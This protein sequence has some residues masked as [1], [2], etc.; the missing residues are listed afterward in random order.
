[1]LAFLLMDRCLLLLYF[2]L[3]FTII[4]Y[5]Y[6]YHLL[7]IS[8]IKITI[9]L[10]LANKHRRSQ[11]ANSF[12]YY[13]TN[14][15]C[16]SLTSLNHSLC[17]QCVA[18]RSLTYTHFSLALICSLLTLIMAI[19]QPITVDTCWTHYHS[20]FVIIITYSLSIFALPHH[21]YHTNSPVHPLSHTVA[22]H[23]LLFISQLNWMTTYV[24][25][26]YRLLLMF[27]FS[28][29]IIPSYLLSKDIKS[30]GI[31]MDSQFSIII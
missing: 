4:F 20:L 3:S 2:W 11:S 10:L 24:L 17:T 14:N 26:N 31:N 27:S 15:L 19:H 12:A 21:H 6:H 29:I 5:Q 9:S 13:L 28:W 8:L 25:I 30:C 18:T 23:S 22:I 7:S 16:L 1:M